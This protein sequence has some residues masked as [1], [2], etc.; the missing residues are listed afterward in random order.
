MTGI[1]RKAYSVVGVL[2]MVGY[3]LQLYFIAA[4]IF[5]ITQADD[6]QKSIYSAFKDADNSFLGLHA[7]NG[8]VIGLLLI[9]LLAV[10]F[11][12][13]LPWTT[14]GLTGLLFALIVVQFLL[15]HTGVAVV[16]ALHGINALVM[17][18]LTG[19]LTGRN[20]AF[21][22]RGAGAGDAAE[23]APVRP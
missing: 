2:V 20:W 6:N 3:F 18:G 9:V 13:R 5:T 19:F 10:S 1:F 22:T 7:T 14:I 11:A 16:S 23:V 15:A 21:G 12:A 17:V 8:S 4:A